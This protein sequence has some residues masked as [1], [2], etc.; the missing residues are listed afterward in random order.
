MS[1]ITWVPAQL[2]GE[3]QTR[4]MEREFASSRPSPRNRAMGFSGKDPKRRKK[5][6]NQ[7]PA[8]GAR[9]FDPWTMKV[10]H[11]VVECEKR[12]RDCFS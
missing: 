4:R 8:C 12:M 9:I 3:E 5:R 7:C 2:I 6:S 11:D 1:N 10:E